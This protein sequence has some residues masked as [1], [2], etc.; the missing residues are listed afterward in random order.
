[1]FKK[2]SNSLL[3]PKEVSKYYG[4]SFGK[5]FLFFIILLLLLMVVTVVNIATT[6]ALSENLKKEIKKSFLKEEISFVIENGTLSNINNDSEYVYTNKLMDTIYI[7]MTEDVSKVEPPLNGY[8]IVFGK[9]GVYI[10]MPLQYKIFDYKDYEYLKNID[11]SDPELFS[12]IKFWDNIFSITGSV[13]NE[14]K[15]MFLVINT[16]YYFIYWTGWMLMLVLIVSIFTKMRTSTF[17]SFGSIFKVSIYNLA[18]FV[19]CL[20]FATLFDLGFLMYVGSIISMVYNMITINE[21]L[22]RLYLN[23]NEGE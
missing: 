19:V 2:L 9:D 17:L 12:N 8:S 6:S 20:I 18:P 5:T 13:L 22:K 4:E 21:V 10:A 14:Y 3:S 23:R 7:S 11:F 15:P 1:M 16:L